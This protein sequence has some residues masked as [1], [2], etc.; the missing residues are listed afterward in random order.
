VYGIRGGF[1]RRNTRN[2][3]IHIRE[4][5]SILLAQKKKRTAKEEEGR[6]EERD[7][8]RPQISRSHVKKER[9]VVPSNHVQPA[10]SY[11]RS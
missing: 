10:D 2:E 9:T 4:E 5:K 7:T 8:A 3:Q 1:C 11:P 6:T